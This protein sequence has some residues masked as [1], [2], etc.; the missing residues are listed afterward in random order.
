M[1]IVVI[2]VIVAVVI[3]AIVAGVIVSGQREADPI[4]VQM[5]IAEVGSL[6]ET[7][8]APGEIEA[9]TKVSISA[10]TSAQIVALPF[11]EGDVVTK[12]DPSTTPPTPAS[13]LV[14]LDDTDAQAR[15]RASKANRNGAAATLTVSEARIVAAKAQQAVNESSLIEAERDLERQLSLYESNDVSQ[16]AVDDARALV[17]QLAARVNSEGL[18]IQA[19]EAN[20]QVLAAQIEAADAAIEQAE[21]ELSYTTISSPIDGTVTKLNAEVGE[22]VVTGTMNNAGTV[23][24]EIADLTEM[25][26]NAEIDESSVSQVEVGQKAI[27]R[28]AAYDDAEIMGTVRSVAL[29][30]TAITSS[31]ESAGSTYYEVEILLDPAQTATMRIFSDLTADVEI[32]TKRSDEVL[33]V[34]SQAVVGRR[35]DELPADLRNAPEIRDNKEFTPV[36]YRIVDGKAK[37]TPVAVGASDLLNTIIVSGLEPGAL[38]VI[39]PYKVL[40]TIAE[41]QALTDEEAAPEKAK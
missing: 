12:G 21:Q 40:E 16:K 20:L 18:T 31:G 3:A 24:L 33:R 1:K 15:V 2:L 29:A 30:K 9:S 26:C 38:I 25:I 22:I 39:G 5:Q 41:G 35:I 13:I 37:V 28:S 10:K 23:I 8:T 36:V 27:V 17:A 11:E 14:Q 4:V 7:V 6:V 19:D 34:P 32:E